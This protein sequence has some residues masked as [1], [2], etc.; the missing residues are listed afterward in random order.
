MTSTTPAA[1]DHLQR[2]PIPRRPG[3]TAR[4]F[5]AAIVVAG[6]TYA[7]GP[8]LRPTPPVTAHPLLQA[9]GD[10]APLAAAGDV[11]AGAS[12]DGRLPIAQRLTFWA[13]RVKATPGDFLS[14]AQL[15]LVEAEQARLT[16]DLDGYQRA[17]ADVDRS[18]AIEPAYPP[19]IRARASIRFTLHDFSGALADARLVLKASPS[20]AGALAL[21]GDAEIELGWPADAAVAYAKLAT[22][23]PG[24]WLDVR[25]AR[26]ASATGDAA[27]AL[28]LTRKA[29]EAGP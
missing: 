12:V 9:P 11:P 27:R 21:L 13:A 1:A 20:D 16:V 8:W 18:L 15:A 29:A 3:R 28:A 19:T 14:L 22:I 25:R 23:A 7:A 24:P 26:L 2:L 17:L 6:T 10:P 5:L 4:L